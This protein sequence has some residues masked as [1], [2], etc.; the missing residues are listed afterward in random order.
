MTTVVCALY[1]A[2]V[3]FRI[4]AGACL[5]LLFAEGFRR[6]GPGPPLWTDDVRPTGPEPGRWYDD[7]W[8][9][10]P[11]ADFWGEVIQPR[12]YQCRKCGAILFDGPLGGRCERCNRTCAAGP[13]GPVCGIGKPPFHTG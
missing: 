3:V 5:A 9:H 7:G 12:P 6:P 1:L 2:N 4:V 13:D 8:H 11:E 10:T